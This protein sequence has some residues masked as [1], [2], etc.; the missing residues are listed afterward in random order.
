MRLKEPPVWATWAREWARPRDCV[1]PNDLMCL[2]PPGSSR[3]DALPLPV[4][5]PASRTG[6][7]EAEA[8]TTKGIQSQLGMFF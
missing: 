4:G 1:S 7:R 2:P 3:T 8:T 5:G 6:A